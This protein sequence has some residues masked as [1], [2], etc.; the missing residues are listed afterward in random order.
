M[1]PFEPQVA[2]EEQS[3][4]QAAVA[5]GD[6]VI[7]QDA[8]GSE[9]VAL[10]QHDHG[11]DVLNL[12]YVGDRGRLVAPSSIGP[13][14][15]GSNVGWRAIEVEIAVSG[16]VEQP[17]GE[18]DA[19][20]FAGDGVDMGDVAADEAAG[21]AETQQQGEA[22]AQAQ[23]DADQAQADEAQQGDVGQTG[24]G[25]PEL[26]GQVAQEPQPAGE[27]EITQGEGIHEPEQQGDGEPVPEQQQ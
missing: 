17:E 3:Y 21:D 9:R 19:E 16:P 22:E 14:S 27:G 23:A 11:N 25:E 7:F 26:T 5:V 24:E 2:A 8:D 15:E 13:V 6:A 10:V 20:G 4:E 18:P 12:V 1:E